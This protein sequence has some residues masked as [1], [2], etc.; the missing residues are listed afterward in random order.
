MISF[1]VSLPLLLMGT[2]GYAYTIGKMD[3]ESNNEVTN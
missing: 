2:F 1:A 3:A